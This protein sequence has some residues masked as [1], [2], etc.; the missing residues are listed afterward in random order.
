MPTRRTFDTIHALAGDL[1]VAL[2]PEATSRLARFAALLAERAVPLGLVAAS[3]RD[4]IL[5]RHVLDS[6]RAATVFEPEDREAYDLGSG[7]GLPG[8][9]LACSMPG[10]RF[11]LVDSRRR[12]AAFLELAVEKLGLVNVVVVNRRVGELQGQADVATAR[13]FGPVDRS[14]TAAW[15][16]LKPGGRLV[17]FAGRGQ[18]R[19]EDVARSLDHPEAPGEVHAA[20]LV[21]SY[22]PLVIMSRRR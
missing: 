11:R 10:T 14:W 2:A 21:E 8:I 3:D 4:R 22:G 6:L 15:G 1:G 17:Y 13:A 19:P 16:L 20:G 18:D 9:V 12:A 7:A 5:E